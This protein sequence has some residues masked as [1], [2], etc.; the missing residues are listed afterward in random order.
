MQQVVDRESLECALIEVDLG[1]V[2]G[3]PEYYF[4]YKSRFGQFIWARKV[5]E[6]TEAWRDF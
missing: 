5:R 3:I 6:L 1:F 4:P 2:L